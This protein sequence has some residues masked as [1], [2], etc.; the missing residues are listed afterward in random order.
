VTRW[1]EKHFLF[2][3]SLGHFFLCNAAG[4]PKCIRQKQR[5]QVR[6]RFQRKNQN[7]RPV[8][9][10]ETTRTKL[11]S[12]SHTFGWFEPRIFQPAQQFIQKSS[13]SRL[14]SGERQ[15]QAL[16]ARFPLNRLLTTRTN[17]SDMRD[18]APYRVRRMLGST[19]RINEMME[20]INSFG[21][22]NRGS[23][24]GCSN[25]DRLKFSSRAR[26]G[27]GEIVRLKPADL[28]IPSHEYVNGPITPRDVLI[29]HEDRKARTGNQS[30][31]RWSCTF[32]LNGQRVSGRRVEESNQRADT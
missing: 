17:P 9:K 8:S 16:S 21:Q 1:Q 29:W 19:H 3:S 10:L 14:I 7:S 2:V 28:M 6:I 31:E 23:R 12:P 11:K 13:V 20:I 30:A 26:C 32:R 27:L 24:R 5:T 18:A 4:I 15:Q 25:L 22:L